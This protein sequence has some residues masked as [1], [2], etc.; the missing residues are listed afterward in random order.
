MRKDRKTG[1]VTAIVAVAAITAG[2]EQTTMITDPSAP[3]FAHIDTTFSSNTNRQFIQ[4]ERLGN[5]LAMEVFVPKREHSGHDATPPTR[6]LTFVDDY[7]LFVTTVAG[8]SEAYARAIAAALLGTP[9]NP[10]DK[11]TVFPNRAP[12][13]TASQ[14]HAANNNMT[15]GWLT[16]A[17]APGVGYGGR[18]LAGDDVVDKGLGAV[19]GTA[20]G[21]MDNVS[22]GL[23]TDNVSNTNP[24]PLG[25]FPYFPRN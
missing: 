4:V 5:P 20:L 6:D 7:V 13:V 23:V 14:A 24:P 18:K 22:P 8:R 17:L 21:N 19:F 3:Q 25:T 12:G 15:V 11:I 10:G 16:H 2:C 1:F 9:D